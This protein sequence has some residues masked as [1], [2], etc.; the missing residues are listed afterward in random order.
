MWMGSFLH[1]NSPSL[2]QTVQALTLCVQHLTQIHPESCAHLSP[3]PPRP[4]M[5]SDWG[6][7]QLSSVPGSELYSG[8]GS[9]PFSASKPP[10]IVCRAR[11]EP[12]QRSIK[13]GSSQP[14][15][16][17]TP[18][19]P[20]SLVRVCVCVR[21]WVCVDAIRQPAAIRS[22]HHRPRCSV[23]VCVCVFAAHDVMTTCRLSNLKVGLCNS[24]H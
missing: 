16:P 9:S 13:P 7:G 22:Y 21:V 12:T 1:V 15:V 10:T 6:A 8:V 17:L 4:R 23:R 2:L 5:C 14:T 20:L 24:K 11:N 18:N 3:S 19:C